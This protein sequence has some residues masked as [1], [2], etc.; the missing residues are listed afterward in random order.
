VTAVIRGQDGAIVLVH[1]TD[2]NLWALPGGARRASGVLGAI[3]GDVRTYLGV[4]DPPVVT[5]CAIG[6]AVGFHNPVMA[7]HQRFQ[8]AGSS[9]LISPPGTGRR[10]ILPSAGSGTGAFGRGGRSCS[11]RCGR[12]AL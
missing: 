2:N 11:A 8:A 1:K 12:R 4:P 6:G 9:W 3:Q 5:C 7:S 10:R